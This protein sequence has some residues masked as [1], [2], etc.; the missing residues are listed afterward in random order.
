VE[1]GHRAH[2]GYQ[3]DEHE[4]RFRARL[5]FRAAINK[6]SLG[7][8]ETLYLI[9]DGEFFVSLTDTVPERFASKFRFRGGLGYRIDYGRRVELLYMR[10]LTRQTPLQDF[11]EDVNVLYLGLKFFF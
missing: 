4:A 2:S 11:K 9:T 1:N 7:D 6:E 10:D 3:E 8:D 5:E